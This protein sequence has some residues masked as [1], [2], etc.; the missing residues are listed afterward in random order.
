MSISELVLHAELLDK[1]KHHST[2]APRSLQK[3][4][5]P[6]EVGD[7]CERKLGFKMFNIEPP[8]RPPSRNNDMWKANVGTAIHAYLE[9]V[10][11]NDPDYYTERRVTV[12]AWYDGQKSHVLQGS[13]DLFHKPSGTVLDWKTTSVSMMEDYAR[14]KLPEV[15]RTQI[16]LYGL[17]YENAG[18][19][20]KRVGLVFLPRDN[21]LNISSSVLHVEAYD[22]QVAL[23]AIKR[24]EDIAARSGGT[25]FASL[26]TASSYCT[27]CPWFST[28]AKKPNEGRCPGVFKARSLDVNDPFA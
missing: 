26:E 5:G 7:P 24:L 27:R 3:E 21:D 9:D 28:G 2:N 19:D 20:V 17:G 23:D 15:Y 16:H 4:I 11:G 13:T 25:D 22:R 12:G 8:M 18:H 14:G 6:S 10:F 1:I